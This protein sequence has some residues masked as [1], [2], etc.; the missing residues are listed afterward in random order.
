MEILPKYRFKNIEKGD[1]WGA[2]ASMLVALPSAIAF[3]V[4]IYLP[5]GTDFVAAGALSGIFGVV[6]IGIVAALLGG[7]SRLISAPC[8]PATAVLSAFTALHMQNGLEPHLIVMMMTLTVFL[9][10]LIQIGFGIAGI[11]K[12]IKF[13]PYT[14]VSGYLSGVG[15]YIIGSQTPKILGLPS[16]YGFYD[17]IMSYNLW[18]WQSIIVGAFTIFFVLIGG[19]ITNKI[20]SIIIGLVGGILTYFIIS[21]YDNSLLSLESNRFVIGSI[22][23]GSLIEAIS[24]HLSTFTNIH[25]V[26]IASLVVSSVVLAVLLS[27]DTLKT[28]I[29]LDAIT[30]SQH[31][32]NKE[33]IA[34][35]TANIAS[36]LIGGAPGAGQM[37]ATLVNVSSGAKTKISGILEGVFALVTFLLLANFIAWIPIGALAAILIVVGFRMIDKHSFELVKSKSTIFDFFIILSVILTALFVSLIAA[38]AIG[39][40]LAILLFLKGQ[41]NTSIV[42]R[43]IAGGKIFSKQIRTQKQIKILKEYGIQYVVYELQGSLFF[44]TS[45]QLYSIVEKDLFDKK[46]IIF[47]MKRINFVDF[48]A[49]HVLELITTIMKDKQS[50]LIFSRVPIKL[51]TGQDVQEYFGELGLVKEVQTTKIFQDLDDALEWVEDSILQRYE[52]KPKVEKILNLEDFEMLAGRKKKIIDDLKKH[53]HAKS[54]QSG[55]TIFKANDTSNDLYFI[56]K[57]VVKIMLPLHGEHELNISTLGSGNFFGEFSFLESIPRTANAVAS[58][59]VEIYIL[60]REAFDNFIH[61]HKKSAI[62][63]LRSLISSLVLRLRNTNAQLEHLTE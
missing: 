28:C 23:S 51:P 5:L 59:D 39:L 40:A 63:F 61:E 37:G 1:F 43:R 36:C 55:E 16:G 14:V 46:Y 38:S 58:G 31:N 2:F 10:G 27:I 60:T 30:K 15:L 53:I 62:L 9:A 49:A 3:G 12:L 11:G 7:T 47:D 34:Q 4:T 22:Q 54:F 18:A 56:R 50:Q 33:L 42:F 45:N 32:S 41:I 48:T 29:V 44:G 35:G 20:P 13:M 19:K 26:D 25:F 17:A 8:A 57:G 6:I 21:I 24:G 52:L